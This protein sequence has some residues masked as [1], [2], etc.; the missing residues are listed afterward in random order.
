[1]TNHIT[2]QI[3]S[4]STIQNL[5]Q[6][7]ALILTMVTSHPDGWKINTLN[8]QHNPKHNIIKMEDL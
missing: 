8:T 2:R 3:P 7:T 5:A 1:M 6:T 4:V